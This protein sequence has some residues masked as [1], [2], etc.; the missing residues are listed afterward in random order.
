[1]FF[2]PWEHLSRSSS[3]PGPLTSISIFAIFPTLREF[4]KGHSALKSEEVTAFKGE[5]M[6]LTGLSARVDAVDYRQSAATVSSKWCHPA[7]CSSV[8]SGLLG[9]GA[10]AVVSGYSAG[11]GVV[12]GK[13]ALLRQCSSCLD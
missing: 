4:L 3:S 2:V 7:I 12:L 10:V 5:V 13:A 9:D 6:P 1:M 11:G 8:L